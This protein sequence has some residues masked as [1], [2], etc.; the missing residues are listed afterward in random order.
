MKVIYLAAHVREV[1]KVRMFLF[2]ILVAAA[3]LLGNKPAQA[4]EV[5]PGTMPPTIA[6]L[7]DCVNHAIAVGH[8][9]N[10]GIGNSLLSKLDAAQSALDRNRTTVAISLLESFIHVVEAQA[11]FH[12]NEEHANHMVEHAGEVIA[13]LGG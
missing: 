11:G 13:A 4:Q 9:D 2:S 12:I 8:I 6:A 1:K 5:C 3:V 7:A 10:A